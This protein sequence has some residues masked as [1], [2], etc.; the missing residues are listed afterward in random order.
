LGKNDY[1]LL[2]EE[3][4]Q[5]H[6]EEPRNKFPRLDAVLGHWLHIPN[7]SFDRYKNQVKNFKVLASVPSLENEPSL[8]AS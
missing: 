1:K 5:N 2:D 6:V 3:S 4:L 8:T 7:L